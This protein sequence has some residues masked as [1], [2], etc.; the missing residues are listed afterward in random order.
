MYRV[1]LVTD[2]IATIL[3]IA[4]LFQGEYIAAAITWI[5]SEVFSIQYKLCK[6]F[7][8]YDKC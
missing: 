5:M 4:L 2:V 3:S 7:K 6:M 1:Y 8:G